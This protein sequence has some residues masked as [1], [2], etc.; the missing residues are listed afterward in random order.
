MKK[1]RG[2]GCC[3]NAGELDTSELIAG[4]RSERSANLERGDMEGTAKAFEAIDD[5]GREGGGGM[6]CCSSTT[7]I[8]RKSHSEIRKEKN[9]YTQVR[10]LLQTNPKSHHPRMLLQLRRNFSIAR[11]RFLHRLNLTMHPPL[12]HLG[13]H[14]VLA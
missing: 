8:S 4:E 2:G 14:P 11:H 10:S 5:V 1:F 3:C 7:T 13:R 12:S 6:R 9:I